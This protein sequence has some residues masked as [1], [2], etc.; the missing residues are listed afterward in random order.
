MK[1]DE[2]K[3]LGEFTDKIIKDL[4]LDAPSFDFTAKVMAKVST[5]HVSKAT[6][7]T[8]LISK[9]VLIFILGSVL[10]LFIYLLTKGTETSTTWLT[11][12]NYTR[13]DLNKGF[14]FSNILMYSVLSLTIFL[15]IQIH[16][17]KNYFDRQIEN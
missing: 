9:P 12:L 15:F 14:K 4:P 2:N 3:N 11:Q 7:Y 6:M 10:A 5:I 17:L 13:F 16:F 8:P 1:A